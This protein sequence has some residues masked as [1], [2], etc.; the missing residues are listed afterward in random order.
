MNQLFYIIAGEILHQ[1]RH[2]KR[3]TISEVIVRGK[4]NITHANKIGIGFIIN[5]LLKARVLYL[6]TLKWKNLSLPLKVETDQLVICLVFTSR[7]TPFE[8]EANRDGTDVESPFQL[9]FFLFLPRLRTL[10]QVKRSENCVRSGTGGLSLCLHPLLSRN[11]IFFPAKTKS[12]A[13][14]FAHA[15]SVHYQEF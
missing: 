4:R 3:T 10:A 11:I 8:S 13:K 9:F 15:I 7:I 1:I 6:I 5:F 12:Q 2:E 14:R